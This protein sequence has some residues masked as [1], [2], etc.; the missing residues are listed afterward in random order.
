MPSIRLPRKPSGWVQSWSLTPRLPI[1]IAELHRRRSQKIRLM[2]AETRSTPF[3]SPEISSRTPASS[4]CLTSW[5]VTGPASGL[6]PSSRSA[7]YS[8]ARAQA[9]SDLPV[10]GSA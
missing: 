6:L 9:S 2:S 7:V 8:S 10:E 4:S 1:V 3:S 5:S